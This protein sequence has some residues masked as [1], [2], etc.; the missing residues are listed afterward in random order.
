MIKAHK[1]VKSLICNTLDMEPQW[2]W[3]K[4][5][6]VGEYFEYCG[7]L[8]VKFSSTNAIDI[9]GKLHR[10]DECDEVYV[11]DVKMEYDYHNMNKKEVLFHFDPAVLERTDEKEEK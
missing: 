4:D 1:G 7:C 11:V 9:L 3:F 10:M 8:Y 5:L 6:E 2:N